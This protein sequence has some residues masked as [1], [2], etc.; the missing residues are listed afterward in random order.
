MKS[1][2]KQQINLLKK[3]QRHKRLIARS[4]DE[5][6]NPLAAV[7]KRKEADIIGEIVT[8]LIAV[9]L[10]GKKRINALPDL[11]LKAKAMSYAWEKQSFASIAQSARQLRKLLKSI[12]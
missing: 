11:I 5:L 9:E 6:K 10:V 4:F 8:M 7:K 12:Q 3:I 1:T 2:S